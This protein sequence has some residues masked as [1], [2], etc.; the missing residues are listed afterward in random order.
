M[1]LEALQLA[2]AIAILTAYA[3]SQLNLVDPRSRRYLV[4]NVA[5]ASVLAVQAMLTHQLGFLVLEA[6][7]ALISLKGLIG[8]ATSN[9]VRR[10]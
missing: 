5:G 3:G 9:P 4:P 10:T 6:A 2:A 7:W 1:I 8:V